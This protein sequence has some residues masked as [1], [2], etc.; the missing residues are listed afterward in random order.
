[1]IRGQV[2]LYNMKLV[3]LFLKQIWE[4]LQFRVLELLR[5]NKIVYKLLFC[6]FIE[7][8]PGCRQ[9]DLSNQISAEANLVNLYIGCAL[10]WWV[11][12]RSLLLINHRFCNLTLLKFKLFFNAFSKIT[13]MP[14][15]NFAALFYFRLFACITP[16]R[17]RILYDMILK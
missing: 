9:L 16:V 3:T 13:R 6:T 17:L 1:M 8:S 12:Y 15:A 4:N 7:Y 2:L 5:F 14:S 11:C 10:F